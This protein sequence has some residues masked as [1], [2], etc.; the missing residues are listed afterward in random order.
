[1]TKK[2]RKLLLIR[3]VTVLA[4]FKNNNNQ[5]QLIVVIMTMYSSKLTKIKVL[6]QYLLRN[7]SVHQISNKSLKRARSKIKRRRKMK[8]TM[9]VIII[10]A[11]MEEEVVVRVVS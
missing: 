7:Q 10:R 8:T 6:L 5:S 4:V 2:R 3:I 1:M 9:E 11:E